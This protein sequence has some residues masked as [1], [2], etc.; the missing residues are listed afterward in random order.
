MSSSVNHLNNKPSQSHNKMTIKLS[1]T[2]SNN[3]STSNLDNNKNTKEDIINLQ[4]F[5]NLTK[6]EKELYKKQNELLS[7]IKT[8]EEKLKFEKEQHQYLIESK[9]EEIEFK[10]KTINQL[11][12][13]NEKLQKEFENLQ[14]K[15]QENM[16]KI[17]NKEKNDKNELE[18]QNKQNSL[19]Q[20]LKVKEK[21]LSNSNAQVD[22]FT[23]EKEKLRK[24]L[25]ETV[26]I[27]EINYLKD[28]I[29]IAQEKVHELKKEKKYLSEIKDEHYKCQ[30]K[31]QNLNKEIEK[32]KGELLEIKKQQRNEIKYDKSNIG[33]MTNSKSVKKINPL[34]SD[35]NLQGLTTLERIQRQ[36]Q[37]EEEKIKKSLEKFWK[38]NKDKLLS[39]SNENIDQNLS[40]NNLSGSNINITNKSQEIRTKLVKRSNNLFNKKKK[41]EEELRNKNLDNNISNELPIIPLFNNQEKKILLN[42]LPEK[43]LE[44]FERR[45]EFIDKE[46]NNL[47]RKL[48][49]ETKNLNKENKE[50]KDRYEFSNNQLKENEEKNR[51]LSLKIEQQNKEIINLQDKLDKINKRIEEK[52]NKVKEKDEENKLLLKQIQELKYKYDKPNKISNKRIMNKVDDINEVDLEEE[53]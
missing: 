44:K 30:E 9:Q 39:L 32:L 33:I 45:Y 27:N 40:G 6:E 11:K 49:F 24:K 26:N 4:N 16:D 36:N 3:D 5:Q 52:K 2:K 7:Q 43:E 50:L 15:A 53:K 38:I 20:M 23:K 10:T 28:Q 22:K 12:I 17:E 19:E 46:K 34:K 41:F 14:A 8:V 35:L 31:F 13:V 42:I 21:E 37:N 1:S 25:D 47:Q 18:K 29:K 48:V 51:I